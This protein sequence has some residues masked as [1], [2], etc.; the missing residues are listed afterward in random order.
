MG[1]LPVNSKPYLTYVYDNIAFSSWN[2]AIGICEL[3]KWFQNLFVLYEEGTI[4]FIKHGFI[5]IHVDGNVSSSLL[6][7]MQYGFG[8]GRCI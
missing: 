6:K 4:L 3:V 8:L 7:A 1:R 5:C 2:I